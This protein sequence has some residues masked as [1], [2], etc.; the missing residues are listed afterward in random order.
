MGQLSAKLRQAA[1]GPK[2]ILIFWCPGCARAHEVSVAGPGAIWTWDGNVTAPTF[3][4]SLLMTSGHYV[5]GQEGRDCWCTYEARFGR[6]APF[7]CFRC[8]SFVRAGVIEFLADCTHALAGQK[9][10]LPDLPDRL[11]ASPT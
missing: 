2:T 10:P 4:P 11:C 1:H 9:V 8:H 6:K 3:Q 7:H 5:S